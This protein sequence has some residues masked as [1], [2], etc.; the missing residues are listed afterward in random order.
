MVGIAIDPPCVTAA[1]ADE[2]PG[3]VK[4]VSLVLNYLN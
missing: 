4:L 2:L 1:A 3:G